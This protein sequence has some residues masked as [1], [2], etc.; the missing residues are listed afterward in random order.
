MFFISFIVGAVLLADRVWVHG[1]A[2][3]LTKDYCDAPLIEGEI[4]MGSSLIISKKRVIKVMHGGRELQ[5]GDYYSP[6]GDLEIFI[7]PPVN[8][9]VLEVR[10]GARFV[11]GWC[12]DADRSNTN[13]AVIRLVDN[14]QVDEISV[15]GAWAESFSGGVKLTPNVFTVYRSLSGG[16]ESNYSEEGNKVDSESV[17]EW[18]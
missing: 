11:N 3:Y 10:G 12:A 7:E 4:M 9:M 1:F 14:P 18:L 8:Q 6:D 17:G 2:T 5:H 13:G 16:V 15:I